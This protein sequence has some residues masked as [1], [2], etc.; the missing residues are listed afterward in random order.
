[1]SKTRR[2]ARPG[3]VTGGESPVFRVAQRD[4]TAR[5]G[6]GGV[7]YTNPAQSE[8]PRTKFLLFVPPIVQ[9]NAPNIRLHLSAP[10]PT[11]P[12]GAGG[13]GTD[14]TVRVFWKQYRAP[15]G[16]VQAHVNAQ[17]PRGAC[18]CAS[19]LARRPVYRPA[20]TGMDAPTHLTAARPRPT[21][22][23]FKT[24]A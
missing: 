1:M 8:S 7:L 12:A 10:D 15:S 13:A 14:L 23:R 11:N 18:Q 9:E 4:I 2:K 5:K 3:S 24:N 16:S 22:L 20:R 19:A 6:R 17:L 21:Q